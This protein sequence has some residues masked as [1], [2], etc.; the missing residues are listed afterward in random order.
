MVI[1]V[2]I[3][4]RPRPQAPPHP[5]PAGAYESNY[6]STQGAI[7]HHRNERGGRVRRLLR[8]KDSLKDAVVLREVLDRPVALRGRRGYMRYR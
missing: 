7:T 8:T 4:H 3:A 2:D 5:E 1:P 6:P